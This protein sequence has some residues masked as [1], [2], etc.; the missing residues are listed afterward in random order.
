[1]TQLYA[2][3]SDPSEALT[4]PSLGDAADASLLI[5]RDVPGANAV[6]LEPRPNGWRVVFES[7]L[8]ETVW[9]AP[10]PSVH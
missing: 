4:F 6:E 2:V 8:G 3:T 10:G 7:P 5:D 9:L 1:M